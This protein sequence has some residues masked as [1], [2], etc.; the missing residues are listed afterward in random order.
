MND[1]YLFEAKRIDNG[2]WIVGN[3]LTIAKIN[4]FICTGKVKLDGALK[5]HIYPEM[6]AVD[7]STLCQC[8]GWKDKNKKLIFENDVVIYDRYKGIVR[9]GYYGWDE[10]EQIGFYIDWEK[11]NYRRDLGYWL[12]KI[13]VIGS[14]F[15]NPELMKEE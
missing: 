12:D 9:F 3:F 14:V 4:F 15:D 8:T 7:E 2:E 13:S 11:V 10:S 5:G 1:R 6:Y